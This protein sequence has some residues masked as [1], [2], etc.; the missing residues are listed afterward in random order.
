[1][2]ADTAL[3]R[4]TLSESEIV[5]V[6]LALK[7]RRDALPLSN[8]ARYDIQNAIYECNQDLIVLRRNR[9]RQ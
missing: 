7:D 9:R 2:T 4:L 5:A 3:D 8:P 1:M 6:I